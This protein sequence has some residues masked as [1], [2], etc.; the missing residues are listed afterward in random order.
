[1]I[2]EKHDVVNLLRWSVG[3]I[4][5]E[6]SFIAF[7]PACIGAEQLSA[8]LAV[9]SLRSPNQHQLYALQPIADIDRSHPRRCAS[10][11]EVALP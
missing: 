9:Q 4:A 7:R 2:R 3:A 5:A 10:K 11:D 1:M 6:K 8:S